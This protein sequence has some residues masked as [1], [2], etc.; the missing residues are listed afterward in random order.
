MADNTP[1]PSEPAVVSELMTQFGSEVC[2]VQTTLD[3]VPTL[4]VSRERLTEVLRF[5]RNLPKPYVM[6]YDLSAIDERL[7]KHR[8]GQPASDFTVFYHLLSI[9]RNS[10]VRIKVALKADDLNLPTSIPIWPN[11][12]WYEREVWDLFG[13]TFAG[14]PLLTRILLPRNWTGHPL[15]KDYPARA[16]EFDPFMLD[17]AKQDAEQEALRFNPE[18]WGMKKGTEHEDYMFLNLGPNHPSAHGAFRIVLQL[19]GEEIVDCVPDIGYHHRG[20]EKMAERQTWHSYIPYTDRIDYLGGVMNNM[21]YVL[22]VEKL[23]GIEVPDRVKTIRVMLSEF[24]RITSHLLFLGTYIQDVGGMTPIF[25]MFTDRQ[26]AYDVIEAITGFRMHPA[27]FR[28]GGVAHD[29]PKGWD[30]LVRDFLDWM[31][32]RLDEYEKAAMK[33]GILRAR[34]IDVAQYNSKEALEW[35]VTGPG[36]RA[37]GID[38]DLRKARPYSGYENFD[39]EVP[40]AHNGD[41]YDRGMVRLE[42]MR[43]SLRIIRQCL[44]NMPAGPYKADHPLTV[45]PP[46]EQTL[47]HIETLIT[48]FLSVS[49]G[50]IMPAGESS[51]MIEATK[52]INSYYLI[53]DKSTMSYRTRIRTPSYPHLQQIPSVIRG[54]MIPDLIA[55]LAS[56]DFVMADVD[57]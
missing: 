25:F 49:W 4:W 42:E 43:Q 1:L 37:T 51:Q 33:N 7:R 39:F 54:S 21:P 8:Q 30:R 31:P 10:D 3:R 56:I 40:L 11:A 27:W 12:N 16:T 34:T 13:I 5:L 9:E 23:A 47:Q 14:H 38:Y 52:G 18:E 6:L 28:I 50:P 35:G 15:C 32:K 41:A 17:A 22:A 57:R 55:Y 53:S 44:E 48:H 20:A 36:L 19:D 46:K 45:P 2:T 24:F 26:K 29:L